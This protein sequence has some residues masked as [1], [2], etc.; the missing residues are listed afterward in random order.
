MPTTSK[1]EL[2]Q[3]F[4]DE[5][6][7]LI[8]ALLHTE[9]QLHASLIGLRE[10]LFESRRKAAHWR[11]RIL[12]KIHPDH[13]KHPHADEAVAKVNAMYERMIRSGE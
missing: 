7:M 9:G 4:R 10:E 11:R 1:N 5:V 3:Y 13:S 8:F 6:S 12:S 2:A